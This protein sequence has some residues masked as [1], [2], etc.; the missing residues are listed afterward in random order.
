[1]IHIPG[2]EI[3]LKHIRNKEKSDEST[4]SDK[5]QRRSLILKE[6]YSLSGKAIL[7][8]ILEKTNIREFVKGLPSADWYWLIKKVGFDDCLPLLEAASEAQ[9]QYLLDL[10]IWRKD[11][12]HI[13]DISLWLARLGQTDP[14]RVARWLLGEGETLAHYYLFKEIRV[15]IRAADEEDEAQNGLI[16]LDGQ[17]YIRVI[18]NK[19]REFI[20]DLLKNMAKEDLVKYQSLLRGLAGILPDE[21]EEEMYRLKNVRLAEYGFLPYEEAIS[22]YSP[23]DPERLFVEETSGTAHTD[24]NEET[25]HLIPYSP[26]YHAG[27]D[28]LFKLISDNVTDDRFLDRIR[29][30]F[31]GLCNQILSADNLVSNELDVLIK[32]CRKASGF[33]NVALEKVAGKDRVKAE[34]IIRS[35]TLVSVFQVGFGL[36]LKLKWEAE[37]WFKKSWFHGQGLKPEFWGD[38]WGNMLA[39]LMG[40]KPRLYVGLSEE[41]EFRDFERFSEI[42]DG[43]KVIGGLRSLD[44]LID[45]LTS[46]F[47]MEESILKAS[48]STFHPLLFN[49]WARHILGL[50]PGFSPVSNREMK[51]FFGILRTNEKKM[52]YRMSKFRDIF[53]TYFMVYVSGF[54]ADD[55]T[56]LKEILLIIW[57]EFRNE[58]ESVSIDNLDMRFS[59]YILTLQT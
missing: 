14:A 45:H 6:I 35:N 57:E 48:E 3:D 27:D 59:K 26:L 4:H 33:L 25:L 16:T 55:K 17:F 51:E 2:T 9:W 54:D 15:E 39:G 13:A 34:E 30:E 58:Y 23:L 50:E 19:N 52:P 56:A 10:E 42:Q 41:E 28:N 38:R 1:L 40:D 53:I 8:R 37:R 49:L 32:T 20:E 5:S 18:H 47:H 31:A 7:D 46:K 22:V 11:R 21:M 36:A 24:I 29:I 44:R 43:Y 12:L